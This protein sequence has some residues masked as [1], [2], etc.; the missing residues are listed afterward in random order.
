[1]P[2]KIAWVRRVDGSEPRVVGY[3]MAGA[4]LVTHEPLGRSVRWVVKFRP[5]AGGEEPLGSF[6][7]LFQAQAAC[8]AHAEQHP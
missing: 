5:Q 7:T 3:S 6:F 1:M 8:V 4:Y 2:P